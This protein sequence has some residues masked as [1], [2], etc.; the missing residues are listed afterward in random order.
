MRIE[1]VCPPGTHEC[2]FPPIQTT[3]TT[4][5]GSSH[6]RLS[7]LLNPD[8]LHVNPTE[9]EVVTDLWG[10]G[11]CAPCNVRQGA[12]LVDK[13]A[14]EKRKISAAPGTD[15][16]VGG[17]A[18]ETI[19]HAVRCQGKKARGKTRKTD[20]YLITNHGKISNKNDYFQ[21]PQRKTKLIRKSKTR[22][23]FKNQ[24]EFALCLCY[25]GVQYGQWTKLGESIRRW[26]V[27]T[28]VE[29]NRMILL[30]EHKTKRINSMMLMTVDVNT[31][32]LQTT[33]SKSCHD[34]LFECSLCFI[35]IYSYT[36]ILN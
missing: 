31:V 11:E 28:R 32:H 9:Y 4:S 35:F 10:R 29:N 18:A 30:E 21:T 12:L 20:K 36:C 2:G 22:K 17:Q 25:E 16:P 24:S 33:Q 3:D 19:I 6:G 27:T 34:D 13:Q 23:S 15:H 26:H 14:I 7:A 1:T 5:L 8:G